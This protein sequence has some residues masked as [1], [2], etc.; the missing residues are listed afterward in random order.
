MVTG[1]LT[2]LGGN[3]P[4]VPV[5]TTVKVPVVPVGQV[6]ERVAVFAGGRTTFAGNVT[7]QATGAPVAARFTVPENVPIG[8]TVIMEVPATV[9]NVVIDV[10]LGGVIVKENPLTFTETPAAPFTALDSVEAAAAVP[11]TVTV[12]EADG[13]GLQVTDIRP[14]ALTLAA[15]PV[16]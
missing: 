9:A 1:M 6:T 12:K 5:T 13:R 8:V 15:Q 2:T 16:G 4:L 11:V 3:V 10:G 7:V 14:A